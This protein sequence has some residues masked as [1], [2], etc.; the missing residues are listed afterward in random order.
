MSNA[1]RK[2]TRKL[3]PKN[4]ED[5][6]TMQRIARHISE[7][8]NCFWQ[9]F[10][11]MQMSCF[12]VLYYDIDFS[13]QKLKNYNEILRKNNEKIKN[14]STIRAEEER[15]IKNIGFDCEREA[16]NFPYRAKIRMYGKNPKQ[17]Q[18]KSVNSNMNDGI[19][20]YLVIAVY[21]LHY[22][23]KFSGEL[24]R[25]WWNRMLDFSKNYVEGMNDDHVV[26]YFKQECDLDIAE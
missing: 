20:C 10:K 4:Y 22:N 19:E 16:R 18:I 7:S 12:Y 11:S 24:I 17:N 23:Y 15:F 13:K 5:K 26:K 9:T 2:K 3:E 8:D 1:L 6:F 14:V 21:T 25:E